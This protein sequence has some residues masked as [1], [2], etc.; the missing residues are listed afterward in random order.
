MTLAGFSSVLQALR[1]L[2][3]PMPRSVCQVLTGVQVFTSINICLMALSVSG[4]RF[5]FAYIYKTIPV[6]DDDFWVSLINRV[7]MTWSALVTLAKHYTEEKV[8]ITEVN[9][10]LFVFYTCKMY[11]YTCQ[12]YFDT[13][14]IYFYTCN[15]L[16]FTY[17]TLK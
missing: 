3:G 16:F 17:P 11:V 6:M 1:L 7:I 8:I 2:L 15:M 10:I 12:I 4:A 9:S 13:C 14:Q 5:T